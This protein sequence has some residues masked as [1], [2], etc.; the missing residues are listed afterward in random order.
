MSQIFRRRAASSSWSHATSATIAEYVSNLSASWSFQHATL[1]S[2][3]RRAFDW[4][5]AHPTFSAGF[6]GASLWGF[7]DTV[8]QVHE[9][10]SAAAA[11]AS[12]S[13]VPAESTTTA[14]LSSSTAAA[15]QQHKDVVVSASPP[16][17]FNVRR[18]AAT[19]VFG[20]AVA[21]SLGYHWYQ[22]LDKTVHQHRR[23]AAFTAKSGMRM[24][25]AKLALELAL[26]HP[27]TL[28]AFW[29]WLGMVSDR[30]SPAAVW[31]DLRREFIPT[32]KF[33]CALW[34]PI[35]VLNFRLVPVKYQVDVVNLG[36]V[37]ESIVLSDIHA[38]QHQRH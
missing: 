34:T 35:D 26:W 11:A 10:K 6:I 17:M 13:T 36:C 32:F 16:A 37:V 28:C 27:F 7:G 20:G 8:A 30:K 25:G 3:S 5:H 31:H 23:L 38:S 22:W 29:F 12:P 33:E 15:S 1:R 9:A 18:L 21:G 19:A 4:L 14:A 2:G 24:I